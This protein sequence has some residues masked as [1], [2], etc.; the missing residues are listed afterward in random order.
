MQTPDSPAEGSPTEI[1][2]ISLAE[3][4]PDQDLVV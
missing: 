4:D 2:L 1:V 3:L